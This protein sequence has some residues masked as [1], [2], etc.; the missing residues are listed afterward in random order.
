MIF[1]LLNFIYLWMF[2]LFFLKKG[3]GQRMGQ[4]FLHQRIAL[5]FRWDNLSHFRDEWTTKMVSTTAN[6]YRFQRRRRPI[7]FAHLQQTG[8]F[9]KETKS[10]ETIVR[11]FYFYCWNSSEHLL[12]KK[13]KKTGNF[14]STIETKYNFQRSNY[15]SHSVEYTLLKK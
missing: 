1:F 3:N 12:R 2:F 15:L 7:V 9:V 14:I 8:E 6:D 5:C 4:C 11:S 13:T 10:F